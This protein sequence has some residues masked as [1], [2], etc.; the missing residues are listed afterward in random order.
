MAPAPE[1]SPALSGGTDKSSRINNFDLIRLFAAAQVAI[2]HAG[3]NLNIESRLWDYLSWFPGVPIFFFISGFLI[4][5][6]WE[7]TKHQPSRF[8]ENRLLRLYPALI[9]CF[10][11]TVATLFYTGFP[12]RQ[13]IS[14]SQWALWS[15]AQLTVV[16]FYNPDFLRG[17]GLGVINGSLWTISVEL[18]FYVLTPLVAWLIR[19]KNA[20]LVLFCSAS[21]LLHIVNESFN[22][23]TSTA[24][25]LL[26]VSFAPWIFMFVFGAL[27][28]TNRPLLDFMKR[29]NPLVLLGLYLTVYG[30]S[31]HYDLGGGTGITLPAFLVLAALATNL[32]YR[33]PDTAKRLLKDNDISY[34]LYIYH[35]PVY[36]LLIWYGMVG[37]VNYLVLGVGLT[38]LLAIAS[39]KLIEQP[40][41]Q[42]KRASIRKAPE[43]RHAEAVQ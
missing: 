31:I 6:S 10:V 16:Q 7:N 5:R 3:Y 29:Q 39:W 22:P 21:V 42:L 36:N 32:A 11:F 14:S 24:W 30:I 8:V 25:K 1:E 18:Q 4:V 43:L 38:V 13:N 41:M 2:L 9:V 19:R 26:T 27:V 20:L 28:S 34:G 15:L 37:T 23:R 33:R 17:Y 12:D 35:K 40:A